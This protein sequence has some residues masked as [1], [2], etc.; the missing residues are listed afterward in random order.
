MLNSIHNDSDPLTHQGHITGLNAS[1]AFNYKASQ[2]IEPQISGADT[3]ITDQG[4]NY[5]TGCDQG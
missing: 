4:V 5:R 1:Q 3:Y 2:T